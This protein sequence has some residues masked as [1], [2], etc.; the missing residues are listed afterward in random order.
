VPRPDRKPERRRD[1][2]PVVAA[3]F[4][5]LGYR[6]TTT[7][8]LA[9][10]CELRENVL[11]RLWPDKRAM[12]VASID[13]VYDLSERVWHELLEDVPAGMSPARVILDHEARHH[14]EHG[15]YRIVFAGLSETDDPDIARALRRL[16]RRFHRF[17]RDR[18]AEHRGESRSRDDAELIAW[19]VVGLGTVAN[20]GRE[21]GLLS[22]RAR[23]ALVRDVGLS[24]L[25]RTVQ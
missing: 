10:R 14:G 24:L 19:A 2:I 9:H 16:Y 23:A 15:L 18:V 6:R 13:H 17:I 8:E 7:A 22:G 3:T 20:I 5:E 25:D 11:Y 1:L 4:A 12:F 21:L